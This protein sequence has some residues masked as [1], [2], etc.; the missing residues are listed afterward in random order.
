M[1][2][3]TRKYL[4]SSRSITRL[5]CLLLSISGEK[6]WY[7]V[8]TGGNDR[9]GQPKKL[10]PEK[11]RRAFA[12]K[13]VVCVEYRDL[14]DNNERDIFQVCLS[15]PSQCS[16]SQLN[17]LLACPIGCRAHSSRY[18]FKSQ[19]LF[20]PL[21][22]T[23]TLLPE[24]MQAQNTPRASFIRQVLTKYVT[25]NTLAGPNIQWLRSRGNDFRC[26]AQSV[27]LLSKASNGTTRAY[28]DFDALNSWIENPDTPPASLRTR[29]LA[30]F[31]T[32][33]KLLK[34]DTTNKVFRDPATKV[35]PIEIVCIVLLIDR[36]K[37]K[38]GSL[39]ELS[40]MILRMRKDVR[41]KHVDI[42]GNNKVIKSMVEFIAVLEKEVESSAGQEKA[43]AK[44]KKVV[45]SD[46]ESEEEV[47]HKKKKGKARSLQTQT[48]K[49][50]PSGKHPTFGPKSKQ[51]SRGGL[52]SPPP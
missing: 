32:F 20:P 21:T 16:R 46:D 42:R 49:A 31:D 44:R 38:I 34:N 18:G 13:Q 35:A 25:E 2:I 30:A 3:A 15:F 26:V 7:T 47:V 9:K 50:S 10:L 19:S 48:Q 43:T 36:V 5:T 52:P 6:Y 29:V 37:E 11:Y 39:K 24:R 33:V 1:Q 17:T 4:P 41:A 12:K 45:S 22:Q 27:Y 28:P 23:R 14:T 40:K 51:R 8:D